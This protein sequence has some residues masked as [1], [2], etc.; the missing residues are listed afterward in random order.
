MPIREVRS[1]T[2]DAISV[3]FDV[4]GALRDAYRFTQGQF[5]TLKTVIGGE[6]AR[7]SYS[8]CIGVD[9]YERTGQLRVGIKRVPGGKF[10]NFANDSLR[11]GQS[12]DVMTPDG[13]FFVP[14]DAAQ[15]RH[16]VGFAGGSGITPML[17]LIKTTLATEPG[18]RFTLVYGNRSTASIIFCEELEDLKNR[19]LGRLSLYHVLSEEFQDAELFNGL[20]DQEKCAAFLRGLV[21]AEH[22]DAAFICGPAPMMDAAEAALLG[23]G[24]D[25]KRIHVE[26]FGT[27]LPAAGAAKPA[28]PGADAGRQ[29]EL[30]LVLDG[31]ARK[32]SLPFEGRS[33]LD[34]GLQAG[35]SLPYAC[36]GGVCCTCRAKVLEGEV[37]M[38]KNYPLEDAEIAQ[39][40][41]LTC[42]AHPLTDRLV[43][44]YDER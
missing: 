23:A 8:I 37:R 19:H 17:S 14:L 30:T 36:K 38:K 10:S 12:L 18:S 42:Q 41:V 27:P 43:I 35:L 34:A 6:E 33:V 3:V 26:R 44:S 24:V 13:R 25:K 32:L 4:P 21:S 2:A 39:G 15:S 22:I 7:R 28:A 29:A 1:E 31:K 40:F 16:Y 20:L 5:L 9:D 11:P